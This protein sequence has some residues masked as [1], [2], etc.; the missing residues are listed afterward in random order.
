MNKRIIGFLLAVVMVFSL[1]L[2]LFVSGNTFVDVPEDAWYSKA[3]DYC[4]SKGLFSGT[5]NGEF[6]PLR[7]ITR[8]AFVCVL[9]RY[10]GEDVSGSTY[11]GFV[12]VDT[13]AYYYES[14]AWACNKG[15]V[16]GTSKNTFSPSSPITRQQICTLFIRLLEY[17]AIVC[18]SA[19]QA[20]MFDDDAS[21]ASW[22]YEAVMLCREYGIVS[23]K[24][25]N[26]FDPKGGV[27]RAQAAQMFKMLDERFGLSMLKTDVVDIK[28]D[29]LTSDMKFLHIS[30]LHL[31]EWNETDT[32]AAIADQTKRGL[33]FDSETPDRV[34][35]TDRLKAM[36]G[37]AED[38]KANGVIMTGDIIDAPSNGNFAFLTEQ[39]KG[40][41]IDTKFVLGNH[42]WTYS[43]DYQSAAQRYE[44]VPKF[45]E[46]FSKGTEEGEYWFD[47]VNEIVYDD[48]VIVS[49]DNSS[50]K[51][52]YNAYS[53]L[54]YY[55]NRQIPV[56]LMMHVPIYAESYTEQVSS[57]WGKDICIGSPNMELDYNTKMFCDFLKSSE[58]TVKVILAGHTH[59]DHIDDISPNNDTIQYT[60]GASYQGY[61]RIFNIHG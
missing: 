49:V 55:A 23:G 37:Y 44:N 45:T 48:F 7:P 9:A 57:M 22:S 33:M 16:S 56:I 3:V 60:L 13:N 59:I 39:V 47:D 28:I 1:S 46:L 51:V 17:K 21:I 5:G 34:S 40:S 35:R 42:D 54:K 50:D 41:G 30:D 24:G 36:Y 61:T 25:G 12:D 58:S 8:A 19:E 14:M 26:L 15:L 11:D 31:T 52:S 10:S 4:V 29:G 18:E 27:T 43:A 6:S 20:P 38:I 32:E 53:T 2:P